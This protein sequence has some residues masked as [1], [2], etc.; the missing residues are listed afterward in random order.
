MRNPESKTGNKTGNNFIMPLILS[1]VSIFV[2]TATFYQGKDTTQLNQLDQE[3]ITSNSAPDNSAV[4]NSQEVNNQKIDGQAAIAQ[5][6]ITSENTATEIIPSA[7]PTAATIANIEA[8][9]TELTASE[10]V[11]DNVAIVD[12]Q[13]VDIQEEGI[14]ATEEPGITSSTPALAENV[15]LE[16]FEINTTAT[17]EEIL[18]DIQDDIGK[19][20]D[21][22]TGEQSVSASPEN[23]ESIAAVDAQ[24][25]IQAAAQETNAAI[26]FDDEQAESMPAA[27]APVTPTT[28]AVTVTETM[29]E[30]KIET[31]VEATIEAKTE[32]SSETTI[33]TTI[34]TAV[35]TQETATQTVTK[36]T[37]GSQTETLE[38]AAE[39][40]LNPSTKAFIEPVSAND[41]TADDSNLNDLPAKNLA[42]NIDNSVSN[43][44]INKPIFITP[45]QSKL[46]F[47]DPDDSDPTLSNEAVAQNHAAPNYA[48]PQQNYLNQNNPAAPNQYRP[49]FYNQ[50]Q[51]QQYFSHQQNQQQAQQRFH[52]QRQQAY[53][54][55]MQAR[56]QRFLAERKA[57]QEQRNQATPASKTANPHEQKTQQQVRL[58]AQQKIQQIQQKISQLNEEIRQLKQNPQ[59][60]QKT[61]PTP[62]AAPV[63]KQM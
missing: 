60:I 15:A 40:P 42:N 10:A 50:Q 48:Y 5:N 11:K 2:V 9:V 32:A 57:R 33:E 6:V 46:I 53:Q 30:E 36:L 31:K 61:T 14:T 28:T 38:F 55:E 7:E 37:E 41:P 22:N 49:H 21:E 43:L 12:S 18:E 39:S 52:Q 45:D 58:K 47:I 13:T 35:E 16:I 1:A 19:N 62:L 54:R 17:T 24:A 26:P 63:S 51:S 56:H 4:N 20:G 3:K 27:T 8:A 59:T 23:D 29:V 44:A 34:E 25:V